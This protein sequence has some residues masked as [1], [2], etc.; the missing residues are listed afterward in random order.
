M[1]LDDFWSSLSFDIDLACSRLALDL[2]QMDA[3]RPTFSLATLI[4]MLL[5]CC[6]ICVSDLS[7]MEDGGSF[8]I[9]VR[10][11]LYKVQYSEFG[12]YDI[13]G[14]LRVLL[15]LYCYGQTEICIVPVL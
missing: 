12:V 11:L 8:S 15:Q 3:P 13:P 14:D 5:R 9:V 4:P 6:Q 2:H 1:A 10:V 7:L